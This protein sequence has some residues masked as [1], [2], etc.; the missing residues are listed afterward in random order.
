MPPN[1]EP[2]GFRAP[3]GLPAGLSTIVENLMKSGPAG[4]ESARDFLFYCESILVAGL[5]IAFAR[6]QGH[7]E[8]IPRELETIENCLYTLC[9]ILGKFTADPASVQSQM[10]TL[11]MSLNLKERGIDIIAER[12]ETDGAPIALRQ[13]LESS[14]REVQKWITGTGLR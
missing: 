10:K 13:L 9:A 3:K 14:S 12:F 8:R 11:K 7:E 2:E 1:K 6:K 5:E 4:I